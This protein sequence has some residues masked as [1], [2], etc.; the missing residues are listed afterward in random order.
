MVTRSEETR[1]EKRIFIVIETTKELVFLENVS[2]NWI[3]V[4]VVEDQ[5]AIRDD[6]EKYAVMRILSGTYSKILLAT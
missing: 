3:Q 5:I 6:A 2:T 1:L 4:R